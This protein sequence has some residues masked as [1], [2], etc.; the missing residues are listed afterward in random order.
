[1]ENQR[2]A[3]GPN[4]GALRCFHAATTG[5]TVFSRT[6]ALRQFSVLFEQYGPR[7]KAA[8]PGLMQLI[9]NKK[10]QEVWFVKTALKA[11]DAQAAAEA[12]IH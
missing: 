3:G 10:E 4:A 7:A 12:G 6:N 5:R 2:V 1:M 8:L 11:I 9:A